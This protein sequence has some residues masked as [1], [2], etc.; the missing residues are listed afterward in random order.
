MP[1]K[2]E[3]SIEL[4][5]STKAIGDLQSAFRRC[6]A[7]SDDLVHMRH[8]EAIIDAYAWPHDSIDDDILECLLA[9]NLE[10]ASEMI[11]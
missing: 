1:S 5:C 2:P 10:R 11:N 4:L 8:D 7:I 3:R 6:Q 9:L